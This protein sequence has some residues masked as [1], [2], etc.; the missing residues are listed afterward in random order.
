MRKSNIKKHKANTQKLANYLA[1]RGIVE[2]M[3]IDGYIIQGADV[4]RLMKFDVYVGQYSTALTFDK[5]FSEAEARSILLYE[6][7]YKDEGRVLKFNNVTQIV[8]DHK[9]SVQEKSAF[10]KDIQELN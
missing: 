9:L 2:T 10:I 4:A 1:S 7:M 3:N 8:A 5:N 6:Q